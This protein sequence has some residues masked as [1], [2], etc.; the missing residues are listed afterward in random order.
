MALTSA[1]ILFRRSANMSDT[2]ATNGG[3]MAS[4]ILT[5]GV[6]NAVFPDVRN[7]ERIAGSDK[8]RKVFLHFAPVDSSQALDVKLVPWAPTVADDRVR[9][10]LGTQSDVQT[11]IA[12]TPGDAYGAANATAATLA[13]GATSVAVA[14]ESAAEIIFRV[15]DAVYITDKETI[16]S[17]TGNE[18]YAVLDSVSVVGTTATLGFAAPLSYAYAETPG[19][20]IRV[21]SVIPLG[22]VLPEVVAGTVTSAA[23][24]F[25]E[26]AI[27][28]VPRSTIEDTWTITFSSATVYAVSG[29]L[30]GAVGGGAVGTSFAPTNPEFGGAYFTLPAAAFG[31]TFAPGDTVTF[32]TRPAARGLWLRRIVPAGANSF[33]SNAFSLAVDCET[34]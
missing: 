13:A 27:A 23:G 12:A 20:K 24:T 21:A 8:W 14:L 11:A 6:K 4:A 7:A 17:P 19:V 10:H 15:G 9:V 31:G 33:S 18:E 32:A 5:T 26:T 2:A 30:T 29:V 34:A 1:D 3:R 25:N 16:A 28:V 22:D